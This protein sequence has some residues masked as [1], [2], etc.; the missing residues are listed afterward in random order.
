MSS[1][2]KELFCSGKGGERE[3]ERLLKSQGGSLPT[4]TLSVTVSPV[5]GQFTL[6]TSLS[7]ANQCS[8]IFGTARIYLQMRTRKETT[9]PSQIMFK[10]LWK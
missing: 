5:P 10:D 3:A 2:K 4:L 8:Y 7:N 1:R 6:L 9:V